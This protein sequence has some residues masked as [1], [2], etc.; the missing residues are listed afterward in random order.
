MASAL[1]DNF[2]LRRVHGHRQGGGRVGT[3]TTKSTRN[4]WRNREI[5][6]EMVKKRSFR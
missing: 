6:L 5:V 3:Y 1:L 2:Q 4:L